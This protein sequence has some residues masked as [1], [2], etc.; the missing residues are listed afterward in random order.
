MNRNEIFHSLRFS[1]EIFDHATL[2][3]DGGV[4]V[5][6]QSGARRRFLAFLRGI[7]N[8]GVWWEWVS[9]V[10]VDG[11]RA[12]MESGSSGNLL[13]FSLDFRPEPV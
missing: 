4:K 13:G 11:C 3:P 5:Q 12:R 7:W 10:T 9:G 8:V 2:Y 6:K 1:V